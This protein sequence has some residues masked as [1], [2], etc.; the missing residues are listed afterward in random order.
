MDLFRSDITEFK[1]QRSIDYKEVND[2][3]DTYIYYILN[4]SR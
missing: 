2:Q 4:L 1:K 3:K